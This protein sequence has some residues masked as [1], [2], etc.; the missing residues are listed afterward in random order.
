MEG[1]D[2]V[3]H[4][5]DAGQTLGRVLWGGMVEHDECCLSQQHVPSDLKSPPKF[6]ISCP[7]LMP[8]HTPPGH[9]GGVQEVHGLLS[10]PHPGSLGA[11]PPVGT[12]P[13]ASPAPPTSVSP[14]NTPMELLVSYIAVRSQPAAAAW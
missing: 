10:G 9:L 12:P 8:P 5:L 7:Q 2:Q 14:P 1:S 11:S 13:Q 6:G 3:S 4:D